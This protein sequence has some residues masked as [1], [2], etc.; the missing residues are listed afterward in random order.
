MKQFDMNHRVLHQNVAGLSHAESIREPEP[1]GNCLNWV[2]G[3]IV[4]SRGALLRALGAEPVWADSLA[5]PYK[6]GARPEVAT[7][8]PFEKIVADFDRSQA[9]VVA[10]LQA[11]AE[12]ALERT[13]R[14]DPLGLE[15]GFI[16]FHESYHVGQTGLHRRLLG[17]EGA[18]P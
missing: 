4:A 9:L 16:S 2:V 14:K 10:G 11:L 15:L 5:L 17:H 3:H 1:G 13:G 6:R 18:I 12:E 7:L 8:L